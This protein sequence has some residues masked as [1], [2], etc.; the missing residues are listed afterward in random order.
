M[1]GKNHDQQAEVAS[2]TKVCTAFTVCRILEEMGIYSVE[3]A[4][5]FYIRV[6]RKAAFTPGTSAYL[7]TDNRLSIYDCMCALMLPSGN[8]SAII[9]ATEFGRWLFLIS[10]K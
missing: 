6:S 2:M 7:Q 3:N 10:D 9:F 8:D 4:K 1:Y 5:N